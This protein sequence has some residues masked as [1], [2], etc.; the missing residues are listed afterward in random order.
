MNFGELLKN[1]RM[2][3]G[4]S[5]KKLAPVL[6]L[7][8][9]YIS[10]IENSKLYPSSEVVEKFAKYFNYNSDELMLSAGK[11]PEDI[12]DILQNNPNEALK[13]LRKRFGQ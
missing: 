6:G 11:I 10:K 4:I 7:D 3:K 8:Y 12:Q 1:L 2:K 5:I 13:Y 9:T